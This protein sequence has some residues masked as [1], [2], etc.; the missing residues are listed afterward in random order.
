MSSAVHTA[1]AAAAA[2]QPRASEAPAG[3]AEIDR[4]DGLDN[5]LKRFQSGEGR[6]C[7]TAAVRAHA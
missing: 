5:P 1:Q 4:Q 6:P 3:V 2:A 7:Q